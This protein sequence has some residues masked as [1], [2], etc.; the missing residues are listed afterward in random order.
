MTLSKRAAL[1][2]FPVIFTGYALAALYVYQ[3]Q[4]VSLKNLEQAKLDNRISSLKLVFSNYSN[5]LNGFLV[6]IQQSDKL[7][8]FLSERDDRYRS[9]ALGLGLEELV[10]AYQQNT[11]EFI[12]F[13]VMS[14]DLELIYYYENSRDPFSKI[15]SE[16][17]EF[18]ENIFSEKKLTDWSLYQNGN[19]STI[20]QSM[21][22]DD[23]TLTRPLPTHLDNSVL[24]LATIE[25]S[26]FDQLMQEV[27]NDY[28]MEASISSSAHQNPDELYS[29]AEIFPGYFLSLQFS[30]EHLKRLDM[31]LKAG[32]ILSVLM[33]SIITFLV[34]QFL[35]KKFI[36]RPI[37]ELD[38]QLNLVLAGQKDNVSNSNRRDEVSRLGAKFHNLF[39]EMSM[40]LADTKKMSRT[41]ALTGL[42][43]RVALYE[44]AQRMLEQA[45][46]KKNTLHFI[47]I[48]LDNFKFVNDKYGHD[49]R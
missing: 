42:S 6:S 25:P 29:E 22:I 7:R 26:D 23:R 37:A 32:L 13:A 10:K 1:L 28:F 27:K 17:F 3:L 39:N 2:I 33:S 14:A 34:L 19:S 49:I 30:R 21:L 9:S 15:P 5:Y 48:D 18:A 40:I 20:V 43:N 38:E 11:L 36:T 41:D 8:S 46:N 47:Y 31:R 44:F 35:I 45:K 4:S 16:Q 12:S 24:L